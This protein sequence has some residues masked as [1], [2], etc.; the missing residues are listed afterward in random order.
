MTPVLISVGSN[1]KDPRVQVQKAVKELN[2]HYEHV[3][4]SS[5]Y[6]T[7]PVGPVSQA[8]FVNATVYFETD[9]NALEVLDNLLEI[10]RQAGR[11]RISET[12]KGPRILDLDIILFGKE[13]W[14]DKVLSIPH[15]RFR[16]RRFVLEPA[17]EIASNMLDPLTDKTIARLLS[18][19]TDR[20]SITPLAERI[21][22]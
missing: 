22:V 4:M 6:L 18:E 15:P 1:M 16:E 3:Q 19:C 17:S 21:D 20:C 10:E 9:Q 11:D 13:I 2:E 12:P 8:S 7:Q 5:L 14:S